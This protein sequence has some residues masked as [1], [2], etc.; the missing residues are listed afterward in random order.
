MSA[1]RRPL[2]RRLYK[3]TT[4]FSMTHP[5]SKAAGWLVLL[6]LLGCRTEQATLFAPQGREPRLNQP[7]PRSIPAQAPIPKMPGAAAV[8]SASQPTQRRLPR[9]AKPAHR[10]VVRH[11]VIRPLQATFSSGIRQTRLLTHS[12]QRAPTQAMY[13]DFFLPA[14]FLFAVGVVVLVVG[15]F[16][17]WVVVA[18]GLGLMLAAYL[19]LKLTNRH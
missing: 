1:A 4:H 7:V 2:A 8:A 18:S 9:G 17:S 10:V 3:L 5:Y 16:T 12:A 11:R 13:P 6:L 15:F 14:L 19:L